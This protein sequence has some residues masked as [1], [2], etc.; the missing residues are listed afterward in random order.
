MA[1]KPFQRAL[2]KRI[3]ETGG[4]SK[5]FDR[6]AAGEVIKSIAKDYDCS[7]SFLAHLL[8]DDPERRCLLALARKESASAFAEEAMQIADDVEPTRDEIRKAQLRIDHRVFLAKSYDKQQFGDGPTVQVEVSVQN[9][10]LNALRART[11]ALPLPVPEALPAEIH[12]ALE[13]EEVHEG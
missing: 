2:L 1:G 3:G 10:H 9:L 8:N 13:G 5:I 6:I 7:R 12:P 4:W 11:V